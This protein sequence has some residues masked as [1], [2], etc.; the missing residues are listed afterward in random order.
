MNDDL[1]YKI[2]EDICKIENL[3]DK[4]GNWNKDAKIKD[5]SRNL[6]KATQVVRKS[7]QTAEGKK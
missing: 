5:V 6:K 2:F 1:I 4:D 7:S 3:K